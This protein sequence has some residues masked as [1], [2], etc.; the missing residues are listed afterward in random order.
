MF[1]LGI[2]KKIFTDKFNKLFFIQRC[3]AFKKQT[4]IRLNSLERLITQHEE[5]INTLD[6]NTLRSQHLEN[7]FYA[8]KQEITS[9]RIEIEEKIAKQKERTS[10]MVYRYR[11]EF[12]SL[13]DV[14]NKQKLFNGKYVCRDGIYESMVLQVKNNDEQ[15]SM[16][17]REIRD[18]KSLIVLLNPKKAQERYDIY[19][20]K[21]ESITEQYKS[22][23]LSFKES[24]KAL[25][26]LANLEERVTKM[27][28]KIEK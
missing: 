9:D 19:E 11:K 22:N 2:L 24:D 10:N 5:K 3:I 16:Y 26:R 12:D 27:D 8:L 21:L 14:L 20:L 28:L 6:E 1:N 13:K 18:I 7:K 4:E 17:A 25:S 15:L 23:I